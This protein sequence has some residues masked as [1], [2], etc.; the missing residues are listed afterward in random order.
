M[1][2]DV[3]KLFVSH[4]EVV[5]I[6]NSLESSPE[7]W[8]ADEHYLYLNVVD[9]NY[10]YIHGLTGKF[11]GWMSPLSIWIANGPSYVRVD[12]ATQWNAYS[13]RKLWK[14]FKKWKKLPKKERSSPVRRALALH[15]TA[16]VD[17]NSKIIQFRAKE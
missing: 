10:S 5:A 12:K 8:V 6:I 16:K 15:G 17:G 9:D 14:A 2:E 1:I 7:R 3:R 11:A 4:D 13:R